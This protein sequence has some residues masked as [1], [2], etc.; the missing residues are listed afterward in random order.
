[1]KGF[2]LEIHEYLGTHSGAAVVTLLET[3]GSVPQQPGARIL[4]GTEGYVS[5][6]IG[7]GK[8]EHEAILKAQKLINE[9][10]DS[11]NVRPSPVVCLEEWNLDSD[12]GMNCGGVAKLFFEIYHQNVWRVLIFGAGH[13]SQVMIPLLVRLDCKVEC[14]DTRAE[15]LDKFPDFQNLK[16]H[17]LKN[18]SDLPGQLKTSDFI[19]ILTPSQVFDEEVLYNVLKNQV[20]FTGVIGSRKKASRMKASLSEK[21]ISQEKIDSIRCPV[22]LSLHT[23]NLHEISLSILAQLLQ[24]REN[25]NKS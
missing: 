11:E 13:I 1:M 6:T 10:S 3:R 14:F 18:W 20:H 2:F 8:L 19:L 23:K 16:T 7:G 4:V 17:H 9:N 15:W 24:E 21:G 5:G 12:L 22:G 25:L